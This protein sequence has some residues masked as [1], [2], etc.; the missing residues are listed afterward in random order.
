MLSIMQAAQ[1]SRSFKSNETSSL[2]IDKISFVHLFG[3]AEIGVINGI[4]RILVP[5]N[6]RA[7]S[8]NPW[9]NQT[10]CEITFD[11]SFVVNQSWIEVIP[12]NQA[13]ALPLNI[14]TADGD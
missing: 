8:K 10:D 13:V 4:R 11:E 7:L 5:I 14:R 1:Q 2:S 9:D 3:V 12:P 6:Q